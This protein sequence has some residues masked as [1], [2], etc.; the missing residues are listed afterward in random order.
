METAFETGIKGEAAAE[1][2][3]AGRGY[4]ILRKRHKC[5]EGEADIIALSGG[6]LVAV[7]VKARKGSLG[8]DDIVSAKQKKRVMAAL[9]DFVSANPEFVSHPMRIDFIF[10]ARDGVPLHIEDAWRE[11]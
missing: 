10:V 7:E 5:R 2:Y 11:E 3:L 8:E 1:A 4:E 9:L 6:V